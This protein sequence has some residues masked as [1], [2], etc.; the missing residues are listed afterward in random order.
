M[1]DDERGLSGTCARGTHRNIN[2][3]S[4]DVGE[5]VGYGGFYWFSDTGMDSVALTFLFGWLLFALVIAVASTALTGT[6]RVAV[7]Q[8][9]TT[10]DAPHAFDDQ[11]VQNAVVTG[12]CE[13]P[14]IHL[15]R[16]GPPLAPRN[17]SSSMT[18]ELN[19]RFIFLYAT[20]FRKCAQH[21]WSIVARHPPGDR[22]G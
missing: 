9:A 7:Y 6:F 13:R 22:A 3:E 4:I 18:C 1:F 11:L 10:G 5:A 21:D 16:S 8:Y 17:R 19:L 2:G 12:T 15:L 14:N 20:E